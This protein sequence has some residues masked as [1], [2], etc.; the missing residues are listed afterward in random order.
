MVKLPK[1]I[2]TYLEQGTVMQLATAKDNQPWVCTVYFV[3]DKDMNLYWLST[4]SRRHSSEIAENNKIAVTVPIKLDRPVAGV[5]AEGE[6]TRVTG[7]A[8]IESL[9][10][11]YVE[12]YQ[13]GT[14][15]YDNFVNGKNEHV[16]YRFTPRQF[17][18]FDE[19]NFPDD[20]RKMWQ[21]VPKTVLN[22][23]D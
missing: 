3:A 12:K 8:E 11:K 13:A 9:M 6:A 1:L 2:A 20:G 14:K 4:P 19:L 5:Q 10:K 21:P 16:M 15:F 17:V 23:A 7:H 22:T 18:L